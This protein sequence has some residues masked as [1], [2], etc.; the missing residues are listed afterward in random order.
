MN[1]NLTGLIRLKINFGLQWLALYL[2]PF[3]L[4]RMR[5]KKKKKK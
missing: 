5:L 3:K 4:D 2:D 1:T